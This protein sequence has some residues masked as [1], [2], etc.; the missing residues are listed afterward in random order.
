[1]PVKVAEEWLNI[2]GGCEVTILDIGCPFGQPQ[3]SLAVKWALIAHH[4]P[5]VQIDTEVLLGHGKYIGLAAAAAC[6]HGLQPLLADKPHLKQDAESL[7]RKVHLGEFAQDKRQQL[8]QIG[9]QL[10]LFEPHRDAF[11]PIAGI[12]RLGEITADVSKGLPQRRLL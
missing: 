7:G 1:M 6:Q 10:A 12:G 8:I 3:M 11:H 4:P 5:S 2:C 9:P